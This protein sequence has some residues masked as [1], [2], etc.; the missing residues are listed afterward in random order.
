V[1]GQWHTVGIEVVE[2][3]MGINVWQLL[4]IL[5]IVILLF[6]TKRLKGIG[7]DLGGAFKGF[8]KA[9]SDDDAD[10]EEKKK[11]ESKQD[12]ESDTVQSK[13]DVKEKQ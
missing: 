9:V 7:S 1:R 3:F 6:G 13:T 2:G 5:L 11:V 12:A 4:I 8:K 10:F